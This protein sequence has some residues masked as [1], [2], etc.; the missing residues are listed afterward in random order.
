MISAKIN[1]ASC[2]S[3]TLNEEFGFF[4]P[5]IRGCLGSLI[6]CRVFC[7]TLRTRVIFD[8]SYC[9]GLGVGDAL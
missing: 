6:N 1:L 8:V 5:L 7:V 2:A 9:A 4:E 3:R